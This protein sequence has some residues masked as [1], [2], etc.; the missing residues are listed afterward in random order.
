MTVGSDQIGDCVNIG[1]GGSIVYDVCGIVSVSISR[2]PAVP[3][4][5]NGKRVFIWI[6]SIRIS[7]GWIA[8]GIQHINIALIIAICTGQYFV[9][10]TKIIPISGVVIPIVGAA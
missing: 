3:E 9:H 4:G 1:R 5:R 6:S 8:V 2:V 7:Y 10:L